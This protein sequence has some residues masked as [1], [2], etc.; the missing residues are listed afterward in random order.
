M[1][2]VYS[3]HRTPDTQRAFTDAVISRFRELPG[4]TSVGATVLAPFSG[5]VHAEA[6]GF[7]HETIP[8]NQRP[9]T[10]HFSV[11]PDYFQAMGIP[12]LRGRPFFI[13]DT[14]NSPPVAIVSQKLV[15]Q[16][17]PGEDP[18]GKRIQLNANPNSWYEIVGVVGDVRH[19]GNRG[20]IVPQTY[21]PFAQAPK[22]VVTFVIRSE[23][24]PATL[25]PLLRL[26]LREIAPELPVYRLEP[27][28]RLIA[29]SMARERFA[30]TLIAV[31][32]VVA[33]ILAAAGIYG[34]MAYA[35]A[36]RTRE[37]GIRLAVGARAGDLR[38]LVL[39]RG[40]KLIGSGLALGAVGAFVT[41]KLIQS[42]LYNTAARDPF[43][44]VV[45][46]TIL[47]VVALA[48]CWVPARR[49]GRVDPI[50]ALR[51]E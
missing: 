12:L 29:D 21:Q 38:R 39:G 4:V 1:L 30:M 51:A 26:A 24:S 22:G 37:F 20:G 2:W 15:D 16:H 19:N 7:E 23:V 42:L 44:F 28:E 13:R 5:A 47:A 17:F 46:A 18:I 34:V 10:I 8:F 45:T 27:L 25:A 14:A 36:Q 3:D 11:T 33:L 9:P 31:F 35:V 48:A 6:I 40:A 50:S 41:T 49:A 32:S 43:I